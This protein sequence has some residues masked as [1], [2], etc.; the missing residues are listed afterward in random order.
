MT[1]SRSYGIM[2]TATNSIIIRKAGTVMKR[3]GRENR[4]GG[5]KAGFRVALAALLLVVLCFGTAGADGRRP[6]VVRQEDGQRI[7]AP[8]RQ[9]GG[10]VPVPPQM[11]E[12][13]EE[14]S[15]RSANGGGVYTEIAPGVY[16]VPV[17]AVDA[18]SWISRSE[19]DAYLPARL[20]DGNEETSWQFSTE[21]SALKETYVYFTF[22]SPVDVDGLWI[23][24]GFWKTTQD[25][26]Q[27]TR[28]S[29]VR[30]LGIAFRYEGSEEWTDKQTVRLKDDKKRQ[31]WQK[32]SLGSHT[33]VTGVRFRIMSIYKGSRFP[34]D[35]CISE[36]QF[37][38]G[39]Q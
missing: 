15:G 23:K 8:S 4:N 2:K 34:D 20:I 37:V 5:R 14:A 33:G 16:A 31:D 35:V 30:D 32:L 9:P 11:P 39:G 26:D 6:V 3:T 13:T 17:Y 27:Y 29:R 12:P 24:N 18:S 36:V 22:D 25:L 19:P 1:V 21:E 7:I 38:K 10:A 28:N